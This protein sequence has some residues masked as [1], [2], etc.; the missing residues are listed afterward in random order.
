MLRR[1]ASVVY[2]FF[3][4]RSAAEAAEA[5]LRRELGRGGVHVAQLHTRTIDGNILPEGATEFGRNVVL[6]MIAGSVFMAVVGGLAGAFDLMLGM[7]VAMG[8][9][10]GFVTGALMGMVGAM[11]AGT[12]I[13]KPPLRALAPRLAHGGALVLLELEARADVAPVLE[14][15]ERHAPDVLDTIGGF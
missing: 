11:Q 8:V 9:A 1:V 5:E 7:P 3:E 2:A 15:L 13:P 10:L 14:T 12:R 6:A 4:D